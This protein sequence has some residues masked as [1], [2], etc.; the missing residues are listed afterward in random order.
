MTGLQ[1]R[2]ELALQV[3]E[4]IVGQQ[5]AFEHR[6]QPGLPPGT[7]DNGAVF[8]LAWPSA[9]ALGDLVRGQAARDLTYR[10]SRFPR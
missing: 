1:S 5:A 9:G 8:S 6:G 10:G 2:D 4:L 3:I 7:A